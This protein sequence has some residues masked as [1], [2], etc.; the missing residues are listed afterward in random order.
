MR[1]TSAFLLALTVCLFSCGEK[2]ENTDTV[3]VTEEAE[4]PEQADE[5]EETEYE[6]QSAVVHDIIHYDAVTDDEKS[7]SLE[8]FAPLTSIMSLS[9]SY[10]RLKDS[11]EYAR[12]T[13]DITNPK[14]TLLLYPFKKK[15][16]DAIMDYKKMMESGTDLLADVPSLM[17]LKRSTLENDSSDYFL[18]KVAAS[19]FFG[20][21]DFYFLGGAPFIRKLQDDESEIFRDQQGNPEVRFGS[22]HSENGNFFMNALY[23][24]KNVKTKISF[25]PPLDSY[26]SGPQEVNG[27]GS[28]I[29]EFVERIPVQFITEKGIVNGHLIG[30]TVKIVPEY[31]G[32]VSDQP[33]ILFA[34]EE[35]LDANDILAIVMPYD[36]K[37]ITDCKVSRENSFLW[38]ADLNNDQIPDL[39]CVS[40][41]FE[42]ISSDALSEQLWFINVNGEWKIIDYATDLD[43]T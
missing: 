19:S 25:G 3:A 13:Q 34:T 4:Q 18:P 40:G 42:G 31:L 32:C 21:L 30:V 35:N 39:A 26:D 12:G 2:K 1:T 24:K 5:T 28:L 16:L 9:Q 7:H 8:E 43:C 22:Q 29:H 17:Q 20:S 36:S 37:S 10:I 38:T 15:A 41:T 27:I 11:L 33:D 14:D 23:L 6:E